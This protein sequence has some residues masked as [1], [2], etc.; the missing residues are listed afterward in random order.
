MLLRIQPYDMTIKYR[1]GKE[2]LLADALSR[3]NPKPGV[4]LRIE[5]TIHNVYWSEEKITD[6]RTNI[7]NDPEL[8]ELLD[9]V[10][11][12]WPEKI[13]DIP[14]SI[15]HYWSMKDFISIENGVLLKSQQVI[16]PEC[17]QKEILEKL[18]F[19]HQGIE[20]T[21]LLARTCVYWRGINEDIENLIQQCNICL[22]YSRSEQKETMLARD[23]PTKAWQQVGT[24]LFELYGQEFIIVADYYSKMPFVRRINSESSKTVIQKLKTI[25]GEHGIPETVFS[26]GGPCYSSKE[27]AEFAKQWGFRHV[28]SSPHY[29]R[30]NG[31]IERTIQTVKRT[32]KKAEESGTDP[33][34]VMLCVRTTPISAQI[35]SPTDMLYGRTV[36]A[37]LPVFIKGNEDVVSNLESRQKQ[38]KCYY[39]KTAKD[40]QEISI[41]QRVGLQDPK[42]LKWSTAKVIEKCAEPRA[43]MVEAENGAV[44]RRN[45]MFLKEIPSTPAET[46]SGIENTSAS[47]AS[48]A[49]TVETDSSV[50][51]DVNETYKRPTRNIRPPDRLIETM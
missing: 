50:Q 9:V 35:G 22:K 5:K 17:M 15:R 43:Y 49:D 46:T 13:Q 39:D 47:P 10:V 16:I 12:G 34:L 28:M 4:T 45:S 37:N 40:K 42:S 23:L 20:K 14:K 21:R 24:D 7:C 27:F 41:G 30:S 51:N 18:H 48:S 44:L 1:P 32:M 33:E 19:S 38:Q 3:L 8:C 2:L 25:F 36:R 29:P 26:D 31:F 6:V 11:K